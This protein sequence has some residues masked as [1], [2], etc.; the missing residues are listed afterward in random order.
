MLVFLY[1]W[2]VVSL[3]I[4]P[5]RLISISTNQAL[6]VRRYD[7]TFIFDAILVCLF[8][9]FALVLLCLPLLSQV[10]HFPK[11]FYTTKNTQLSVSRIYRNTH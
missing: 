11:T 1:W 9:T 5:N 8:I 6:V 10:K 2:I 7:T 3:E 4:I